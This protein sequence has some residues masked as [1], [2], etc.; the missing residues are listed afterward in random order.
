MLLSA[1]RIVG[2]RGDTE[3]ILLAMEL[4]VPGEMVST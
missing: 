4:P 1:R 2:G 3:L